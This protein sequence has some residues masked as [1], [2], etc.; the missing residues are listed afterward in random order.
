MIVQLQKNMDYENL[1]YVLLKKNGDDLLV[2]LL[3]HPE[4]KRKN[5]KKAVLAFFKEC[6]RR[7]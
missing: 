1:A 4:I 3:A 7:N 6:L 5:K 2:S